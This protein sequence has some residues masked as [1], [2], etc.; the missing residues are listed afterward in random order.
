MEWRMI[1]GF[2]GIYE[3]S[4][5]GEVR[6]ASS[7]EN[8]TAEIDV[9]MIFTVAVDLDERISILLLGTLFWVDQLV[10]I[11]YIPNHGRCSIVMHKDGDLTNNHVDNLEWVIDTTLYESSCDFDYDLSDTCK[12]SAV[13]SSIECTRKPVICVDTHTVYSSISECCRQLDIVHPTLVNCIRMHKRCKGLRFV[14]CNPADQI[15]TEATLLLKS[16]GLG[17]KNRRSK[18]IRCIETGQVFPSVTAASKVYQV[19]RSYVQQSL[20]SSCAHRLGVSF[21]YVD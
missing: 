15:E 21:E 20:K 7:W 12:E 14:F 3:I 10:A 2:Q 5:Y 1:P 16:H 13:L 8:E 19:S 4:T 6:V 17:C 11:T 9:D 18:R